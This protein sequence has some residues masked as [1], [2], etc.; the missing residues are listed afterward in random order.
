MQTGHVLIKMEVLE[1]SITLYF[2]GMGSPL[3][4]TTHDKG[5]DKFLS[6]KVGRYYTP[7]FDLDHKVIDFEL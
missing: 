5:Y 3:Q 1:N 4:F 6:L 7:I 2:Q